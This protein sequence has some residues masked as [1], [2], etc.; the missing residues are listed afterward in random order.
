M[1]TNT[2]RIIAE[3]Q[4]DPNKCKFTLEKPLVEGSSFRFSSRG[5]ALG[6]HLAESLFALEPVDQIFIS[7]NSV[8]I[9]KKSGADWRSFGKDVGQ[10]IRSALASGKPLISEDF[11][12]KLP[13]PEEI[14]KVVKKVLDE[15]I[16]PAVAGHGGQIELLDIK[17]NDVFVRMSGGCQGCAQSSATLK[18]GVEESIRKHLPLVGSVYDTT[19]HAAGTNPYYS[20]GH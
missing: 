14:R 11:K 7:T 1:D 3:P 15:E 2:I 20:P 4:I 10:V 16:N 9:T 18:L 12:K 8:L 6:S 19:D 13:P 17:G 5:Q